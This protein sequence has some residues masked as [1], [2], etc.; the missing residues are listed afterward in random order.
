MYLP[1]FCNHSFFQPVIF[2][3]KNFYL[4]LCSLTHGVTQRLKTHPHN[5][6]K[7]WIMYLHTCVCTCSAHQL[8]CCLFFQEKADGSNWGLGIW[9]R[10]LSMAYCHNH[11]TEVKL[12]DG[13]QMGCTMFLDWAL[14]KGTPLLNSMPNVPWDCPLRS[15]I[16]TTMLWLKCFREK[17][18]VVAELGQEKLD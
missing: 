11:S 2:F 10:H 8:L 16:S 6:L 1:F 12:K 15:A 4:V 3:K 17:I 14:A 13:N 5:T 9:A 18:A 7:L